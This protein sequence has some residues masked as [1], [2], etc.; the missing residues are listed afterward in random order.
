MERQSK[1]NDC[2]EEICFADG[3]LLWRGKEEVGS[4]PNSGISLIDNFESCRPC[5]TF[6]TVY[7]KFPSDVFCNQM[8]PVLYVYVCINR[9]G[10]LG[11]CNLKRCLKAETAHPEKI[12][13][14]NTRRIN[15]TRRSGT[16]TERKLAAS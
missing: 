12:P 7:V 8:Y 13:V 1:A 16:K 9:R 5:C 15:L 14:P 4:V 11:V 2:D 10:I 3:G 6:S